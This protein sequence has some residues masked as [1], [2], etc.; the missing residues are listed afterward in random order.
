MEKENRMKLDFSHGF[1]KEIIRNQIDRDNYDKEQKLKKEKPNDCSKHRRPERQLYKPPSRSA[2][3]NSDMTTKSTDILFKLVFKDE[4]GEIHNYE[5]ENDC[6][7]KAISYKI[8]S[9]CC[10]SNK[11]ILALEKFL[12]EKRS[13]F[14]EN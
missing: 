4:K 5:I 2:Q 6:N 8:G 9:A 12:K 10:L 13:K 7:L 3:K 14:L 11:L 1:M